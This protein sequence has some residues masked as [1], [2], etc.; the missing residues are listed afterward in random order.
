[1]LA[2]KDIS[3]DVLLSEDVP[4]FL[5]RAEAVAQDPVAV[6]EWF[7]TLIPAILSGLFGH[8]NRGKDFRFQKGVFGQLSAYFGTIENQARGALHFHLLLWLLG[9]TPDSVHAAM[10]NEDTKREVLEFLSSIIRE[11]LPT[12]PSC[13]SGAVPCAMH[14]CPDPYDPE[15]RDNFE[16]HI[17]SVVTRTN[18]HKHTFTC[19]KN[20][21]KLAVS[22]NFCRMNYPRE[23]VP[24]TYIDDTTNKI[25]F[26]RDDTYLVPYN[27]ALSIAARCNTDVTFIASGRS[28]KAAMYYITDYITKI[29]LSSHHLLGIFQGALEKHEK[30]QH[31]S[32]LVNNIL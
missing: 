3:S 1:M 19:T 20:K 31:E 15:F 23:E 6:A 13:M 9:V 30:Y 29:G 21:D 14:P 8:T 10:Q 12:A 28:A 22:S 7:H 5:E 25:Y 2:G 27:P 18:F 24:H 4:P 11:C 16:G 17:A 32:L 26:E